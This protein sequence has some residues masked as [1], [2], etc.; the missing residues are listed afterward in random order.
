V[1]EARE[2][3]IGLMSAGGYALAQEFGPNLVFHK[4]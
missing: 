1:L 4:E 3:T 2:E